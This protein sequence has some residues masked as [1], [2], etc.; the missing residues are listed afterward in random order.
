MSYKTGI[1]HLGDHL[2]ETLSAQQPCLS[3]SLKL[4][5]PSKK[6]CLFCSTVIN[7]YY[8]CV[9]VYECVCVCVR[10]YTLITLYMI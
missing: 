7:R 3:E 9:C 5:S 10:I 6:D 2:T 4:V 1:L 8:I